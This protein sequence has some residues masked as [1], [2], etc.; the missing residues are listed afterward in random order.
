M[1][2]HELFERDVTRDIPPVVYFHEQDPAKLRAE[3]SEY[4]ITGGYP[5]GDPRA[6]RVEHGIHEGFVGLLTGIADA[7]ERP[8]G[9]ELPA[10]WISGF[11]GSGKSSFAKLL[12]MAL[13]GVKLD[14]DTPL[15]DALLARDDSPRRQELLDAWNAVQDL[16]D[17]IAVVFD[18]GAVARDNEHI[19]TAALRQLQRRLGY[20]KTSNLVAEWELKLEQDGQ[21]DAFQDAA[22]RALGTPWRELKD[23]RL[24]EDHF[25]H[26]MHVLQ[27]DRYLTPTDWVDSHAGVSGLAGTAPAETIA[28][29]AAMLDHRAVGRTLFLVIDEVSQY[30]HADHDRML[31]LQSFVSDLGR[32]L[33]GRAWL[34]ATGQQKLEDAGD[35]ITIGKLKDRFPVALRVHLGA[36]NIRDVV[37]RRLLKKRADAETMLR[38]LFTAHRSDLKL[39]GY[40]CADITEEDFVEVYPMLPGHVDLLLQITT[41]LRSR[42][43]RTQG[44]DHAIRGLLQLLGELFRTQRLAER[45]VG[46]LVTLDAIF[47]VQHTALDP[48]VQTALARIADSPELADD[49]LAQRAARAVALLELIQEQQP[50]T[51]ELVASCLY[52]RLG[53]GNRTPA[54]R[55]ALERLRRENLVGFSD[56]HGYKIQS[57]AGQEW[58][59]ER[60]DIAVTA[61]VRSE[62]VRLKL[63]ELVDAPERPRYRGVAFPF[64]AVYSDGRA[65]DDVKVLDPRS[66]AAVTVDLR[67]LPHAADRVASTWVQRSDQDPLRDRMVW[68]VGD[69]GRIDA[70][71]RDL[72]QSRAMVGRYEGRRDSLPREKQ[73]LLIEEQSLQEALDSRLRDAV[74]EAYFAGEVYFRGA[75]TAPRDHADAFGPALTRI[76]ERWLPELY[77]HFT[78]IAVTDSELNQLLEPN[79]AGPSTKLMDDGLGVLALD[80]GRYVASCHGT[81]PQRIADKIATD[82]GVSGSTLISHFA[83]PPYGYPPDVIKACVAGLL[84]GSQIRIRP[85]RGPEITS[86]RDPGVRDLFR[87]VKEGLGRADIFPAREGDVSPRDRVAI[88]QLFEQTLGVQLDRENDAIADAVF[89]YLPAQRETLREVLARLARLPGAPEPPPAVGRLGRALEACLGTRQVEPIVVAVK[90][91]LDRLRDGLEQLRILDTDLSDEAIAAL[92]DAAEVRDHHAAQLGAVGEAGEAAE[93][94]AAIQRHL[95]GERPWRGLTALTAALQSVRARYLEVRRRL[96]ADQGQ[97]LEA[98]TRRLKARDGFGSLDADAAHRVLRPLQEAAAD[99]TADALYPSLAEL[100]DRFPAALAAAEEAA[101]ARLDEA[102]EAATSQRVV[103]VAASLRGRELASPAE[104]DELVDELRE[105]LGPPLANGHRV[106]IV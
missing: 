20:S 17:P 53:C 19:H 3:V 50:T 68:V 29:I 35:A 105:R 73:R 62:L 54:V 83:R 66:G 91:N 63:R 100:R 96:L 87:K 51:P 37:H 18:V 93:A 57:S 10:S 77:P 11:Y 80:S 99:T 12:G 14:D 40:A 45:E 89:S 2:I 106:R 74:A 36:A 75:A 82:R 59:R 27:P 60:R 90:E 94:I 9:A 49:E 34:L 55:E 97:R 79:L 52:D 104:L 95:A 21:W 22:G 78:D 58:E 24:A 69:P 72:S 28:A 65:A 41:N 92:R 39:H 15:A 56:K 7:L 43:S 61:D 101:H 85:D 38:E 81:V 8:G 26:A 13:D 30:V 31:R 23:T 67:Y 42:S 47:K 86:V 32:R 6:R 5:P 76:A 103:T 98:A 33:K 16:I 4:I 88:C 46:E 71:A 102:L 70:I 1:Q 25:S 84:R 44:D 48:D 64:A